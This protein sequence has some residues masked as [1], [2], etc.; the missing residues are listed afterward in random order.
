M[1]LRHWTVFLVCSFW[2]L[3]FLACTLRHSLSP[4]RTVTPGDRVSDTVER[5][6]DRAGITLP[7]W[8]DPGSVLA[9]VLCL[10]FAAIVVRI[11][12]FDAA[13]GGSALGIGLIVSIAAFIGLGLLDRASAGGTLVA[14]PFAGVLAGL[15]GSF[16]ITICCGSLKPR[17]DPEE[18]A[19]LR[20]RL[21]QDLL[22][23]QYD[24][25]WKTSSPTLPASRSAMR[26]TLSP[27]PG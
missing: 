3:F 5:A 7:P 14:H 4:L 13:D 10:V 12:D 21:V 11:V 18:A 23:K 20:E 1:P 26:R 27:P 6:F 24:R 9:F 19:L 25:Q 16:V 15:I 17:L 22:V 8:I 2:A